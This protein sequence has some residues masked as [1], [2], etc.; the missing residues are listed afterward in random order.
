GLGQLALTA[1][2]GADA[3]WARHG[4]RDVS[5]PALGAKL[6]LYGDGARYMVRMTEA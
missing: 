5:N 2:Y 4:F 6:A 3:V 1:V